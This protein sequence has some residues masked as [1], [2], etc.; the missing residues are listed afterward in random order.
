MKLIWIDT[1]MTPLEDRAAKVLV[2]VPDTGE[3]AVWTLDQDSYDKY[4]KDYF[5]Q[6]VLK[7][8]TLS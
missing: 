1:Q 5:E 7:N 2:A 6:Q 3:E 8:R 4:G